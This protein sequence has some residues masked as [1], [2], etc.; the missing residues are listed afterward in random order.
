[1]PTN[2]HGGGGHSSGGIVTGFL[3]LNPG[4][5]CGVDVLPRD[6]RGEL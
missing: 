1:M 4:L 2:E 6:E 5:E 3:V